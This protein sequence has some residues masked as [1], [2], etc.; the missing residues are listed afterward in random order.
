[1]RQK[2]WAEAN[3]ERIRGYYRK[4]MEDPEKRERIRERNRKNEKEWREENREKMNVRK[5]EYRKLPHRREYDKEYKKSPQQVIRSRLSTRIYLALKKLNMKKCE[6]LSNIIGCTLKELKIHMER[7]FKSGMSWKNQAEWHIDHIIPC[8]AFDLTD[9][10][11]QKQCFHFT[12]LRPLWAE[13]NLK[14]HK[15][16]IYLM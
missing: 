5:R 7:Q 10:E 11:Q 12:N 13:E 4:A 8:S 16:L 1:M 3:P 9:P 15:K 2:E 14:K 6:S